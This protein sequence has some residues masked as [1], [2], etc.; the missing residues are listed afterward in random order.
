MRIG[1]LSDVH[2]NLEAL[3]AVLADVEQRGCDALVCL[4]DFVGYGPD[5]VGCVARLRGRLRMA[6]VG[7]HD[8]AAVGE[9]PIDDFNPFAQEAIVWTRAHLDADTRAY[10]LA[11]PERADLDGLLFV[12]GSP[13]RPVDEYIVDGRT[14]RASFV[15]DPFRIAFVGHT[16]V[17]AIFEEAHH[18]VRLAEWLPG[19]PTPLRRDHRYIVNAGSVGQ[20]RD[21]NRDA[22]Y[23]VFDAE[24]RSVTLLRVPYDLAVTQR[25][26][27]AALLPVPLIER[28]A[29]GR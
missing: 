11:L 17:P 5:P 7:N 15:A 2:A 3:D 20:P 27:E 23:V 8:R 6:V 13:R 10:L 16:H 22:A 19:I 1:V 21:S 9:R 29:W 25:K 28:L 4:G 26:M 24:E 14:A 18:R 12:H